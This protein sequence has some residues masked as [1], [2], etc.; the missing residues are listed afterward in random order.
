MASSGTE[1]LA[2][3]DIMG[4]ILEKT[5]LTTAF[6]RVKSNKGSAGIDGM[7]VGRLHSYLKQNWASIR[8]KLAEGTY[9]PMAVRR[10]DI[11]K[12]GGG[13]RQLGI[14][15]VLDRFIQQAI[16]Q[17]LQPIWDSSF[18]DSSFGFRPGR[19]A[20]DAVRR[21][22]LHIAAG[23][24]W[25]VDLDLE[26]FFDRVNHDRLMARLAGR[27]ADK[28]VLRL[29]RRYLQSGVMTDG[30]ISPRREGTPQ[31]GPLSP[32]LSNIVLDELDRELERRGHRF[33]RYADDCN[34]YVRS[35]RAG[36]RVMSSVTCFIHKRLRL[37][38]NRRKSAVDIYYRS[39]LGFGFSIQ[40]TGVICFIAPESLIRFKN[41]VRLLTRRTRG[42]SLDHM[43]QELSVYLRGWKGY[44]GFINTKRKLRNLDGWI[45]RRIR[46]TLWKQ[47]RT[48][49]T[50]YKR[51]RALG[52]SHN[53]AML[54]AGSHRGPWRM[55][56]AL[57][58]ALSTDRL[59]TMGLFQLAKE[60]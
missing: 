53:P 29:I 26:K 8:T 46:C 25:V 39:F 30:M 45:R 1:S 42:V 16:L 7:P 23:N 31:G 37:R 32:L 49:T 24:R 21:V 55:A 56:V 22:Q 20:H 60:S 51:L 17:V 2:A 57:Q 43:I 38:V 13:T 34:I 48:G 50:R 4:R 33:V 41:R 36:E 15:T 10:V 58:G 14:P 9:R 3:E 35:R 47:L 44:F 12:P 11:P 27:I 5:N 54:G 28:R 59:S 19:S 40:K 6:K 18:S 52:V